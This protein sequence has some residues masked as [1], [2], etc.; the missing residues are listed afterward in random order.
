MGSLRWGKWGLFERRIG[1]ILA[2]IA[3]KWGHTGKDRSSQIN[4]HHDFGGRFE[5]QQCLEDGRRK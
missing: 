1:R 3:E 5:G 2:C 4:I